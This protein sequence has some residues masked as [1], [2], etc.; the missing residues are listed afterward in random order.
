MTDRSTDDAD[1]VVLVLPRGE[2]GE[3]RISRSRYRGSTFNKLQLWY[4]TETGELRPGRQV[5]TIRDGELGEVIAALQRI[6]RKL[7]AQ[8]APPHE[9]PKPARGHGRRLPGLDGPSGAQPVE[10]WCSDDEAEAF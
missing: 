1:H 9:S 5:V 2:R 10:P 7:G 6:A 4:P 3:L 8:P